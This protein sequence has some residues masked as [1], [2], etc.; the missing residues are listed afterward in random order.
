MGSDL[1]DT[2]RKFSAV[3]PVMDNAEL[4]RMRGLKIAAILREALAGKKINGILDIGCSNAL[5]LDT[6][7]NEL[8]PDFAVGIDMDTAVAPPPTEKKRCDRGRDVPAA[9]LKMH[10]HHTL[11][12]YV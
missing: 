6:V 4:R 11:Q 7:V 9:S 2:A 1:N 5:V 3:Y 12:P 10:G 8:D